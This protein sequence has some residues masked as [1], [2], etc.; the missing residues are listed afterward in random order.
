MPYKIVKVKSGYKVRSEDK[1][2]GTQYKY[3]SKYPMTLD[4]AQRQYDILTRVYNGRER[5][6]YSPKTGRV[7]VPAPRAKRKKS[8]DNK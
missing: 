6:V 8:R 5:S 1:I 2:L 4:K 3:Y 7:H